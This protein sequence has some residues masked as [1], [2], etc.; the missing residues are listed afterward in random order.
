[1]TVMMIKCIRCSLPFKSC[2]VRECT[3]GAEQRTGST[4]LDGSS[5][6]KEQRL[7]ISLI[8]FNYHLSIVQ[9]Y[10][11]AQEQPQKSHSNRSRVLLTDVPQG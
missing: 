2:G 6:V 11:Y 3:E 4:R 8:A 10:F 9:G 5:S 7:P 1:M